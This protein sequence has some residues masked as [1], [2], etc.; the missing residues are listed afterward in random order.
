MVFL[1]VVSAV[2]ADIDINA[3]LEKLATAL[4]VFSGGSTA[5]ALIRAGYIL[6]WGGDTPQEQARAWRLLG[7]A[8]IGA[9]ICAGAIT[10]A[11][12]VQN[13]IVAIQQQ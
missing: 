9:I 4:A 6:Q 10:L 12:L 13:N 7:H 1:H 3:T 2:L 8:V 11:H 5:L